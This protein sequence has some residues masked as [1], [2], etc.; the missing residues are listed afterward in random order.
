MKL[1][2]CITTYNR[3]ELTIKA[4]E[5]VYNDPRIDEIVIVDDCSTI[6]NYDLLHKLADSLEA[7]AGVLKIK[8]H[9]NQQNLGMSR[10]KA[11]A[12]ELAKSEWCILFDSDN[13]LGSDY[14]D[15]FEIEFNRVNT[16][17]ENI[18]HLIF[19][20]YFARPNFD[21]IA[22]AGAL[23]NKS[24]AP[25]W[26]K[27]DGFNC[28]MNTCNYI[29][30]R[31]F[32]LKTYQYNPRHIASDTVWHNYNHLKARGSFIVVPGMQYEHLV[33]KDSGFMQDASG[34]IARAEEV[35]K[36]IMQL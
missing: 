20:P 3:P 21:Y 36:L 31:D 5:K 18:E 7:H 10:N 24:N 30:N 23:Y 28:L 22:Y 16:F 4:F 32:Y 12:I 14:I 9:R 17:L 33:H 34:N 15:A 29:V 26:V 1:S 35:R 25:Q 8:I 6:S 2:L 13:V 27:Q 19:C 11:K